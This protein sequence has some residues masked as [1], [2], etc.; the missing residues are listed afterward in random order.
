MVELMFTDLNRVLSRL[1]ILGG[2]SLTLHFDGNFAADLLL[3]YVT[4]KQ[5]IR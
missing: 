1:Y 2:D 5:L 3:D 4:K